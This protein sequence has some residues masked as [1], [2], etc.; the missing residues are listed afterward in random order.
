MTLKV[1]IQAGEDGVFVAHVPALRGC[2]SQANSRDEA[3]RNIREAVEAWL[4]VEHD[5]SE[6]H[7]EPE[8]VVAVTV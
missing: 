3:I 1:I 5:K 8:D 2:R 4:Q 7:F 6:S